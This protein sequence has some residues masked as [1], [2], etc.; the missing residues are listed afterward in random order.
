MKSLVFT[1]G[2]MNNVCI[3]AVR[4]I[5]KGGEV[6]KKMWTIFMSA[7]KHIRFH[8]PVLMVNATTAFEVL[9]NGSVW[10]RSFIFAQR[11]NK[12]TF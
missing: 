6:R 2:N 4:N 5:L 11:F 3:F 10:N 8:A 12:Q 7:R 1:F 9:R